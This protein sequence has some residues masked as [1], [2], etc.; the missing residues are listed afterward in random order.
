MSAPIDIS[1]GEVF[2]SLVL[3]AIAMAASR[4]RSAGLEEDIAVAVVRS[5]VQLTAIGF[6]INVIFEQAAHCSCARTRR[7]GAW[8]HHWRQQRT[9]ATSALC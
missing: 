6:V 8:R 9:T 5:F 4:W 1:L 7:A 2:A 3:V